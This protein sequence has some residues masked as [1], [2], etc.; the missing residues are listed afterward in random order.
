MADIYQGKKMGGPDGFFGPLSKHFLETMLE[1][2][3]EN[4]LEEEKAKG[5]ANRGNG[6]TTKTVRSMQLG[7]IELG[8]NVISLSKSFSPK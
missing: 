7:S 8:D 1:S 5:V 3:L 4:H 2:E 6:K